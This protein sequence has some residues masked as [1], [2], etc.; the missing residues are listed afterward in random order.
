MKRMSK[1]WTIMAVSLS[2]LA[3]CGS[4][5]AGGSGAE[6]GGTAQTE[7]TES[8][9]KQEAAGGETLTV[10]MNGT[11]ADPYLALF[12]G[13]AESFSKDN[14]WNATI[15]VEAYENEQYKTKLTTLMASNAVPDLFF[16][17]E[18]DYLRPF[19]EG[20]KVLEITDSVY[21][22]TAWVD[23]FADGV[24]EPLTYD[25][26]LYAVPSMKTF[27]VMYYNKQI[28]EENG[29]KIPT[30]YDE[31]LTVCE[32]LKSNG[33][34]PMILSAT[35]AWIPAQFIQQI[36]NGIAGMELYDGIVDGTRPWNDPAHV[37]AAKEVQMMIE[38][39][40]FQ[41]GM[42]GMATEEVQSQFKQGKAAMYFQGAWEVSPI[43]DAETS[44]IKD[45]VGAFTLPAKNAANNNISVGSVDMSFAVSKNCKNPEAAVGFIKYLSRPENQEK[46]L[47]EQGRLPSAKIEI[48]ETKLTPLVGDIVGLSND[49]KGLTP[50]FDRAFGAGEGVEFNNKC[51]AIFGGADAQKSFD[52][53]QAFSEENAGR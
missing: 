14:E 34:T 18:L 6:G 47:Y 29:V 48:D 10:M 9:V 17:W 38:K 16:T 23:T 44:Q 43:L 32:T 46:S 7:K 24:L 15:K 28:F 51:L 49:S 33:V 37:E 31:F 3:G 50:W 40:Y 42:L 1:L 26:G 35:D 22:D 5:T 2:L 13:Y 21:G 41:D 39:G 27:C 20:G 52:E 19:V 4:G 12:K 36:S 45:V 11:T 30:T 53:L 25:E 8:G